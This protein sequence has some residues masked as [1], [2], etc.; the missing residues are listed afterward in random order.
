MFVDANETAS[1]NIGS[2]RLIIFL[3]AGFKVKG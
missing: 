2:A 1:A 3:L